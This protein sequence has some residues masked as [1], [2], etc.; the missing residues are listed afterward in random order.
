MYDIYNNGFPSKGGRPVPDIVQQYQSVGLYL[1]ADTWNS[2][3]GYELK[4]NTLKMCSPPPRR[5][6][7]SS[8]RSFSVA[9]PLNFHLLRSFV[10]Y[11]FSF[12]DLLV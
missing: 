4:K 9:L 12:K 1:S 11:S 10:P 8:C 3:R 7:K 5:L 6:L 2:L